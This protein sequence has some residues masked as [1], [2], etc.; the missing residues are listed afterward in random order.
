M[1][2]FLGET[3]IFLPK[4]PKKGLFLLSVRFYKVV[5]GRLGVDGEKL[6]KNSETTPFPLRLGRLRVFALNLSP[7]A[8]PFG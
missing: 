3:P 6:T 5:K 2:F 1:L 7:N 4:L 8:D